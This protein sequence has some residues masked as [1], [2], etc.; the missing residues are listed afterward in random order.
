M[1]NW[2]KAIQLR[3]TDEKR[4][5][6]KLL[7]LHSISFASTDEPNA[8]S[9]FETSRKRISDDRVDRDWDRSPSSEISKS[10]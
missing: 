9:L 4:D 2:S 7:L 10:R 8:Y 1:S 3:Q 6:F 5:P